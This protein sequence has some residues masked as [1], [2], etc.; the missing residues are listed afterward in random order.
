VNF[1]TAPTIITPTFFSCNDA[2]GT[3]IPQ[4]LI[5]N[6]LSTIWN[7]NDQNIPDWVIF[8][9]PEP[10][11]AYKFEFR[12]PGDYTH[13]VKDF[14]L[15]SSSSLLGPWA[16][17]GSFTATASTTEFQ[18]YTINGVIGQYWLFN[19]TSRY[20]GYQA[21]VADVN[22]YGNAVSTPKSYPVITPGIYRYN[23]AYPS[24][25]PSNLLDNNLA[26]IWN[27]NTFGAA[28]VIFNFSQPQTIYE[29]Q[30]RHTGDTTH[31]VKF[32]TLETASSPSGPWEIVATNFVGLDATTEYQNYSLN[33]IT[34][35][36]WLFNVTSRYS[37]Y[38]AY[39]ADVN[40]YGN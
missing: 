10:I 37:G 28:W 6:D 4:N 13:D 20:S 9:F 5:D 32:F 26:T 25:A 29:F 21:Y 7:S 19:I 33:G 12:T 16:T 1:Y 39:V 35:Q 24:D 2:Y 38:Q 23:N 34:G 11:Q 17:I 8:G 3:E 40:F 22:F 36:Y 30:F 18:N 31:D 15:Q 27:S 14:I